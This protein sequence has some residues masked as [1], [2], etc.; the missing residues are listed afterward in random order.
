MEYCQEIPPSNVDMPEPLGCARC[1]TEKLFLAHAG[2]SSV[3]HACVECL[4]AQLGPR[5][6]QVELAVKVIM[7]AR[8]ALPV[9]ASVS[10][11]IRDAL[12]ALPTEQEMF[13]AAAVL[14]SKQF[15]LYAHLVAA[16]FELAIKVCP[17][18]F[19]CAGSEKGLCRTHA[20][21]YRS[22][23][24]DWSTCSY[25]FGRAALPR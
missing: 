17:S 4:L 5:A 6:E 22:R 14:G 3:C 21:V 25:L 10:R 15:G 16:D 2:R 23:L 24:K 9:E 1:A 11:I 7:D 8:Q 13:V 19:C 18:W 20:L 12:E